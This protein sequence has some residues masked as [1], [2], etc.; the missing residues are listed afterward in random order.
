MELYLVASLCGTISVVFLVGVL[1]DV[2][3]GRFKQSGIGTLYL[4]AS[5]VID[6]IHTD[7]EMLCAQACLQ[8]SCA[9][10]MYRETG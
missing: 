6:E 8:S 5:N 9:A 10:F 4:Q 3:T 1:C 7:N 2:T